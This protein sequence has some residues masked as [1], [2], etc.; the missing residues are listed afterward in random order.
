MLR[1]RIA[2]AAVM[3][4]AAFATDAGAQQYP[5]RPIRFIVTYAAGSGADIVA[6]L[7]GQKMTEA[8]G[9]QV[10][11]DNRAGAGGNIGT[12]LAARATPDGYTIVMCATALVIGPSVYRKLPYHPIRDFSPVTQ[13]VVLPF[14]LV[15]HPGIAAKSVRELV[16]LA[17]SKPRELHYASIGNATLQHLAGELFRTM[18]GAEIVHVPYKGTA[19][20]I[21]DLLAGQVAMMFSGVPPVLPHVKGG[22]LRALAVTT[23]RRTPALPGVP[24]V[25]EAGVPGYEVT[26]WFGVL[27][28]AGTPGAIVRRLNAEIVRILG[29][30]DVKE[31][32]SAQG[33]E[34]AAGTPA[35]F[36]AVL[37]S[38]MAKY[39]KLIAQTGIRAE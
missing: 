5:A 23:A 31:R 21:A 17:R 29:M 4:A 6:R 19:Q 34:P 39:A 12:E 22:K 36:A 11:V 13:A 14:A 24:T 1:R 7:I 16:A 3:M 9:Q 20:Y 30:A 38:D 27:A 25:A 37:K 35:Q 8:W 15:V 33:A 10:V 28:P 2:S 32:L 18:S 26:L